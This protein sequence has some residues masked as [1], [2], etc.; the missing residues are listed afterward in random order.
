MET[1][2]VL[3]EQN[4]AK[5]V[6]WNCGCEAEEDEGKWLV[7]NFCHDHDPTVHPNETNQF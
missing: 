5:S 7:T 4:W 6:S 3:P 1:K 2:E